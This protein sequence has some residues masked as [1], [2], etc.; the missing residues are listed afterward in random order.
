MAPNP[1][2]SAA[3]MFMS[4]WRMPW[5]TVNCICNGMASAKTCNSTVMAKTAPSG[6]PRPLKAVRNEDSLTGSAAFFLAS[7]GVGAS[8]RATPVKR[9]LTSSMLSLRVPSA[10]STML[11][12]RRPTDFR[13]TK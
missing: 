2:A 5:S 10:G 11:A 13:T 9:P 3:T 4:P 12:P 7:A 1:T 8:S 6:P